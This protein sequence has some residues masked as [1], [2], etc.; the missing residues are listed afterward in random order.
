MRDEAVG[1]AAA[2]ESVEGA[3]PRAGAALRGGGGCLRLRSGRRGRCGLGGGN[4]LRRRARRRGGRLD[5]HWLPRTSRRCGLRGRL[6]GGLHDRRL[7]GRRC[8]GLATAGFPA[9]MPAGL[10]AAL[11]TA[12]FAAAVPDTFVAT[13]VV[14]F[15]GAFAG[16]F[17]DADAAAI[18]L[19]RVASL[20]GALAAA[21]GRVSVVAPLAAGRFLVVVATVVSSS[22]LRRL[23]ALSSLVSARP[24]PGRGGSSALPMCGRARRRPRGLPRP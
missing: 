20:T 22:W 3:V 6:G 5:H 11:A 9:G 12:G 15:A 23:P 16:A 2:Q 14:A 7:R 10:A 19:V 21:A 4:R 1:A 8:A 13:L 17:A 18:G 24:S